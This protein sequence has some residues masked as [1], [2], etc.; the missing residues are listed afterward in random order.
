MLNKINILLVGLYVYSLSDV[1]RCTCLAERYILHTHCTFRPLIGSL[2]RSGR[3]V[4]AAAPT[5]QPV[6]CGK[7]EFWQNSK[8]W[9]ERFTATLYLQVPRLYSKTR[10][11]K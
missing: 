5:A 8:L 2:E 6:G 10:Y 9:G 4:G 3:E 7:T 11:A 1:T